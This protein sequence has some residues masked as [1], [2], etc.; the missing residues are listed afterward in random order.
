MSSLSDKCHLHVATLTLTLG[1]LCVVSLVDD[2]R[3]HLTGEVC[4]IKSSMRDVRQA[5]SKGFG[6][7][8]KCGGPNRGRRS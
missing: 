7:S 1:S 8:F 5:C 3:A 4:W 2:S 6:L